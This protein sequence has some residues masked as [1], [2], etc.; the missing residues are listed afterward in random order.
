MLVSSRC[1]ITWRYSRSVEG[2]TPSLSL[3]SFMVFPVSIGGGVRVFPDTR[4]MQ[5][6]SRIDTETFPSGVRVDTYRPV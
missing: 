2:L 1:S 5:T 3:I 4:T 6:W